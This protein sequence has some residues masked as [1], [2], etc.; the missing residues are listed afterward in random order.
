MTP[1]ERAIALALTAH[2]GQT[3]EDGLPHI[4]HCLDVA[5]ALRVGPLPFDIGYTAEELATAAILHD[6]VEDSEGVVT[7]EIIR[8]EFGE[9][10][11]KLVDGVSRRVV[12]GKKEF[13]RDFIYRAMLDKGSRLLKAADLRL[14]SGRTHKIKSASWRGKLEYKYG[15]ALRVIESYEPTTWERE[16]MESVNDSG[17]QRFFVADP[18]GK[19]TEVTEEDFRKLTA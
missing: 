19:R 18:N 11:A 6:S 5:R 16:S 1:I 10:V 2:A 14:N 8:A 15:I 7:L 4:I 9:N 13:Y 17:K 12:D 3:D